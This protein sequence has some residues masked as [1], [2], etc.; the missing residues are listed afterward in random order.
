MLAG[1][2]HPDAAAIPAPIVVA[3]PE[4]AA[5]AGWANCWNASTSWRPFCTRPR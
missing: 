2:A 5:R 4:R 1:S 3:N